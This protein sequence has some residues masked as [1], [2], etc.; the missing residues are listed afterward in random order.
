MVQFSKSTFSG[1][2]TSGAV[3]VTLML[4]GGTSASAITVIVTPFSQSSS[5]AE[6]KI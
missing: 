6:G 2:E 5:S 3:A 1:S 4:A